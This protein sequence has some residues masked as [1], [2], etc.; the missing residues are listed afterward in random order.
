[1][2]LPP[3]FVPIFDLSNSNFFMIILVYGL[4]KKEKE[5]CTFFMTQKSDIFL[6]EVTSIPY[7]LF[8]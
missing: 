3:I 6:Q 2:L 7:P 8:N 1:M 4:N 5:C